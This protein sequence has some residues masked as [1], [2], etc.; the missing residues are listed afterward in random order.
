MY[1]SLDIAWDSQS[2]TIQQTFLES[3]L[4]NYMKLIQGSLCSPVYSREPS[5]CVNGRCKAPS[6]IRPGVK[7]PLSPCQI[8]GFN[9]VDPYLT[10]D[11][12]KC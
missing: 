6:L 4:K 9:E 10:R 3:P 8:R 7:F 12:G 11:K 1:H 2:D 5:P